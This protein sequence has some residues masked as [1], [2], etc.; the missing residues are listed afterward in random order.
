[1]ALLLELLRSRTI[2]RN[3]HRKWYCAL[4][5]VGVVAVCSSAASDETSRHWPHTF[6][7]G[8]VVS[9][10]QRVRTFVAAVERENTAR[11]GL[12][13]R[14]PPDLRLNASHIL[15][16]SNPIR[17]AMTVCDS[18]IPSQPYVV[19]A[20]RAQ[21]QSDLAPMAVSFT[22]GF[23][24]IPVIGLSARESTFSDKASITYHCVSI[25]CKMLNCE[26]AN[27]SSGRIIAE[28]MRGP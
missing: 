10:P 6:T 16:D 21:V 1:M 19:I 18:L 20:S 8:A 2:D 3:T 23:Y 4:L 12:G 9:S 7:I 22:C 27:S 11:P 25:K 5:A 15:M 24:K 14:L 17:A 13:R 26:S 28:F